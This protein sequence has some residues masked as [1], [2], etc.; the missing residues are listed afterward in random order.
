MLNRA[1]LSALAL[2]C[3]VAPAQAGP[4]LLF[5]AGN[6]AVIYAEDADQPW[7][8]ASL[9]KLM[10]AYLT[11]HAIKEGKLK[12]DDKLMCSDAAFKTQPSKVGL[13]TGQEI[14]VDL[15]IR[16]LIVKSANDMAVMLAE[17]LGGTEQGFAVMMNDAAKKL[18]MKHTNFVNASG[19]PDPAQVTSA[20]DLALLTRAI[21]QEFPEYAPVF[22]APN[23]VIGKRRLATHNSLLNT[24]EGADGMKTGFI[25]DSGYNIV[26][27][28]T[29]NNQRLVAVV[30]GEPTAAARSVRAAA[31]LEYGFQNGIWKTLFLP[32]TV[33]SMP[34]DSGTATVSS[35]RTT[36]QAFA[37]GYH[38]PRVASGKKK[39]G[40]SKGKATSTT[41]AS[42]TK[43]AATTD[44][45][46]TAT[47]AADTSK[48]KKSKTIPTTTATTQ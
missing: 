22:A 23:I 47:T 7:H 45:A 34:D 14:S 42:G 33:E 26:A 17:K 27:S 29:R 39:G 48:K 43:P 12:P 35:I 46:S 5:D 4:A 24:F 31:L 6:G 18:G 40:K 38:K 8:P 10:T 20:R 44:P 1:I 2:W 3:L 25:C 11:F 16:A 37:C 13:L 15:A 41:A 36:V 19:L 30:L 21:I 28:A 32:T 9:T